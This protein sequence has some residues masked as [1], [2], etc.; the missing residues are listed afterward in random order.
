M[1]SAAIH[2]SAEAFPIVMRLQIGSAARTAWCLVAL[3]GFL[4]V[5]PAFAQTAPPSPQPA[6]ATDVAASNEPIGNVATLQGQATVTRDKTS[7]PLSLKDDIYK[8]D[9]LQ[10]SNNSALGVTFNDAT[11]FNLDANARFEIDNYI[12]DDS[13]GAKNA[14]LFKV[15][16]GKVAFA[17]SAV[18]KTGDMKIET[19]TAILGI[20]GTTGVIEV[21]A[22]AAAAGPDDVAIKLYPDADGKVGRIEINGRDGAQLGFLTQAASGFAIRR[23]PGARFA[24]VALQISPQQAFRDQGFVRQLRA[25]QT[26]GR[27]IV[28]EQRALRRNNPGRFN[29][30]SRRPGRQ[31][32]PGARQQRQGLQNR[33]GGPGLQRPGLQRPGAQGRP[34]QPRRG[35]PPPRRQRGDQR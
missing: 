32:P 19:P 12:Y 18:A 24:A 15:A 28:T 22:N 10:T 35:A 5:S 30:P 21:P 17:A 23:G 2:V 26:I 27:R 29:N 11:T 33:Q 9:I 4:G 13:A 1:E 14:A 7:T 31:G 6:A 8:N 20:R 34:L 25:T 3:G 16:L